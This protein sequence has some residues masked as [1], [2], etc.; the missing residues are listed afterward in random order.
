MRR[1]DTISLAAGALALLTAVLVVGGV[2][3][4]AQAIVAGL[5]A[6]A[7]IPQLFARRTFDRIPPIILLPLAAAVLTAIQ[8]IPLPAGVLGVLDHAGNQLRVDGASLAQTHPWMSISLDPAGSLRALAFFTILTG[9]AL[10]G[11]RFSASERGRFGLLGGVA[12][13]C[14][15]AAAVTGVHTL[16]S[17]DELYG[18]YAPLH[19]HVSPIFGPLL[20]QNHLGG[21]MAI[22][23]ILSVGLS[24][25]E[26]QPTQLRVAWIVN[27]LGCVIV[28]AASLSRGAVIGMGLGLA[29]TTGLL[30]ARRME[31]SRRHGWRR[32]LPIAIVV[33]LGVAL[34]LHA[35]AGDVTGQIEDTSLTE[36]S[37]PMSKYAAW[38]SSIELVEE[39]PW[40]GIGRNAVESCLT[41]VN[42]GSAYFTYSHLENEYLSAIV[43]WGIPGAL[44][45]AV[46][47]GWCVAT[48]IRRWREGALAAAGLG[49]LAMIMFQSFVDFGVELLG[50]AVPATIVAC[51][52]Q[53]VRLRPSGNPTRQRLGR[54]ALIVG[55]A[56]SAAVLLMPVTTGVSE[57]HDE[58]LASMPATMAQIRTSIERHPLD[59]LGFGLGAD[60]TSRDGDVH[61]VEYLNQ[62]LALHPTHPGL[63]RLAAR[64]LVGLKEYKQAAVEY[65]LAMDAEIAPRRL[66]DEVVLLLP[67]AE[68]AAAAIPTDYPNLDVML[69]TL[70][71]VK[72]HDITQLWLE[73]VAARPQHDLH[74]IDMLFDLAMVRED[75]DAAKAAAELRMSV[76]HT[77]TSRTMLAKVRFARK[78][79]DV[80]L[81]DLADVRTWTG[82]IDEKAA[83]WMIKCD[84]IIARKD[85][86]PALECLH[87]L[88]SSGLGAD[89]FEIGKRLKEITEERSYEAKLQAAQAL[90]RSVSQPKPAPKPTP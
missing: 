23:A 79:Y 35:S 4:W 38:K 25:Y 83:A 53:R 14:G 1:R 27:A 42:P 80:L 89:R 75:F 77:T 17:A 55:L 84:V 90:E 76:A 59:Y 65:S 11:L 10:L 34:A 36:L 61:A 56:A 57:D 16:L 72:R 68:D 82:R 69:H 24:F 6:I 20:N 2:L 43:E 64:M 12:V 40:V 86:D 30:L 41:R 54:L 49:A 8:L 88:D 31:A 47:L 5:L 13:T 66:I 32:D 7:L 44:L 22:G 50:V 51:T 52:L 58:L 46:I 37:K 62:S 9:V 45:L 60:T 15:I 78:E 85:W 18:L 87:Q 71:D 74:V 28:C 26:R 67:T 70:D 21:L 63:H 33:G 39:T 73:R 48:A 29:V 19:S 81:K 3:R